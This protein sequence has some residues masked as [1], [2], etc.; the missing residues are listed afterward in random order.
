MD[1]GEFLEVVGR[2]RGNAPVIL[3]PG[4]A[5][6]EMYV[7]ARGEPTLYK[8]DM[9]YAAPLCLGLAMAR[10]DEERVVAIEGDGS[11]LAALGTL[12]TVGRYAP[13]N[14]VVLVLDNGS[15]GSIWD[16][17]NPAIESATTAGLEF[18]A[19][20]RGCGIDRA[21][22]VRTVEEADEALHRAMREAGPWL[23]VAKCPDR[24]NVREQIVGMDV[25]D[26]FEN[27]LA[28]AAALRRRYAEA[29]SDSRGP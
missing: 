10:P 1:R 12:S 21:V 20:A 22:T 11:M 9:A 14:L 24:S 3:G 17:R 4:H 19:V 16:D 6:D 18:E 25:P 29:D 13:P 23:I 2:H 27:S 28:F 7:V 26:V 5:S 8:M 15:Y